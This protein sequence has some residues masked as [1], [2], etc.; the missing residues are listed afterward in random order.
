MELHNWM[1]AL[2]TPQ[3]QQERNDWHEQWNESR[4]PVERDTRFSDATLQ[5]LNN[6]NIVNFSGD[7][8]FIVD[9]KARELVLPLP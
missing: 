2:G 8:L 9:K 5:V 4:V 1:R 3:D 6:N 7:K